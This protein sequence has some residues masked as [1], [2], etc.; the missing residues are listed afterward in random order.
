MAATSHPSG[1]SPVRPNVRV[2]A[3]RQACGLSGRSTSDSL[4]TNSVAS[5]GMEPSFRKARPPR[6][7][8]AASRN[9]T[10][11][12][13]MEWRPRSSASIHTLR[14]A[15]P[16]AM[17]PSSGSR[18]R[19]PSQVRAALRASNPRSTRAGPHACGNFCARLPRP[20]AVTPYPRPRNAPDTG[21]GTRRAVPYSTAPN[22][23]TASSSVQS[24]NPSA[25]RVKARPPSTS[26]P[27]N[28]LI[29]ARLNSGPHNDGRA[30]AD[31]EG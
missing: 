29:R 6:M 23:N 3:A 28:T 12:A 18:L 9:T 24:G 8:V 25:R 5:S 7:A 16:S 2:S 26:A 15:P 31:L 4:A 11:A 27:P 30:E 20:R 21:H 13:E 17:T 1:S 19:R 22:A 14:L 10:P